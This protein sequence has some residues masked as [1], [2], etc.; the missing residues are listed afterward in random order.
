M[1]APT[2]IGGIRR[3]SE[4]STALSTRDIRGLAKDQQR[5]RYAGEED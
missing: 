3:L 5:Y 1:V 2:T 4:S